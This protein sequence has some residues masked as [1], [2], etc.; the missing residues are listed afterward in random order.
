MVKPEDLVP[1]LQELV[2]ARGPSGQEDEVRAVCRR[3]MEPL[4]DEV[5]TD[6]AGNV[7]GLIKGVS[8]GGAA[9]VVR[10]MTHMDELAMIVKRVNDDGTLRV[11]SLGGMWPANY[12]QGPVDILGN[13]GIMPGILS[14]GPMHT[15]DESSRIWETK[16]RGGDKAMDWDHVYVFTRR[17]AGALEAAGVHAGTRVVIARSRRALLEIED[18]V[19]GY[20]MDNRAAIAIALGSAA[21][22]KAAAKRPAGDVYLV[23][24]AIEEIGGHGAL[25]AARTLPGDIALAVDSGPAAPEYGVDLTDEPV[26]V[27]GDARGVYDKAVSDR[28]LTVGREIGLSP[29]C[30]LWQS[31]ASDAS[32]SKAT[33]QTAQA[34]LLCIA[35]ENTHGFEVIPRKGL[36]HCAR[37]L[38]AYLEK[39]V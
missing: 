2:L 35:T 38:A 9:P 13:N 11:E 6:P 25:Y 1:L 33:G 22:M 18:C 27:Y 20:F 8:P 19:S 3:E 24:T 30:A 31:Y 5:W 37:L 23:M 34:G 10:V 7:I 26:V 17:S 28:L 36:A 16:V 32:L 39:P 12:G 14:V 15:T 4:C 21:W 29:Q